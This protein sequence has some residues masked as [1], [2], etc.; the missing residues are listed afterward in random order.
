MPKLDVSKG[1]PKY[2][3]IFYYVPILK[4]DKKTCETKLSG[5]YSK[6]NKRINTTAE[7]LIKC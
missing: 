2:T 4:I 7:A 5:P 3:V 6:P 1:I